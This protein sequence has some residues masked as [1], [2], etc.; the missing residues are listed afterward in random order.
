MKKLLILLLL[1][2]V[3]LSAVSCTKDPSEIERESVPTK[4]ETEAPESGKSNLV[5]VEDT[6]MR[7]GELYPANPKN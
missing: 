5:V 2:T 3:F 6:D 7:W 4:A 1:L